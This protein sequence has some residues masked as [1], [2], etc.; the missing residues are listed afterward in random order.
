MVSR[1][2]SF[3]APSPSSAATICL[4]RRFHGRAYHCV[5]GPGDL[6]GFAELALVLKRDLSTI[7]RMHARG[8]FRAFKR[9]GTYRVPFEEV[10]RLLDARTHN[11]AAELEGLSHAGSNEAATD[12]GDRGTELDAR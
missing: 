7:H 9:D 6:L 8:A 2:F 3:P 4:R 10:R 1:P 12:R 5:I 11:L